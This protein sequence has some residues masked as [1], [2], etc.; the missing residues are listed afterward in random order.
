MP[1]SQRS[2]TDNE[3]HGKLADWRS[4]AIAKPMVHGVAS[5]CAA[6]E[7]C[8]LLSLKKKKKKKHAENGVDC[9]GRL[10]SVKTTVVYKQVLLN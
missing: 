3:G 4:C 9:K 5:N 10:V 2:E 7:E 6:T 8:K 1:K